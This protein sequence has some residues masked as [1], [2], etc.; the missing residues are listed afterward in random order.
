MPIQVNSPGWRIKHAGTSRGA[1]LAAA[2]ELPSLPPEFLTDES[3]VAEEV[4][5]ERSPAARRGGV[6]ASAR[7]DI[8]YDLEPGQTAVLALRYPSGALTFHRPVEFTTRGM[9]GPSQVRFQVSIRRQSTT[10]GPIT[11]AVKAIVIKVA[12]MAAATATSFRLPRLVEV[13]EKAVWRKKGLKEGWLRLSKETLAARMLVRGKPD[14]PSR[15]LLLIH[16]TFS[17]SAAAYRPLADSTSS[18]G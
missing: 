1:A 18:I 12:K 11:D 16:G 13:V 3:Q 10:R 2:I 4:V 14:S 6:A 5:L 7:L 17:N 9:R 8:S 15:S